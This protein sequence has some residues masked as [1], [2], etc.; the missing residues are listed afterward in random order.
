MMQ[1]FRCGAHPL[2]Q[3]EDVMR[4]VELIVKMPS[5]LSSTAD[6]LV[7]AA[8]AEEEVAS[9]L[10]I[11]AEAMASAAACEA[12]SE[13]K[14]RAIAERARAN[15]TRVAA[16]AARIAA[17]AEAAARA[18]EAAVAIAAEARRQERIDR[19]TKD[20]LEAEQHRAKLHRA[21]R[22]VCV[23]GSAAGTRAQAVAREGG[24]ITR[25]RCK[26]SEEEMAGAGLRRYY[27]D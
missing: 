7:A 13:A 21:R 2:P 16:N 12:A 19:A 8:E 24:C 11:Q 10:E 18:Q 26:C 15:A 23:T 14:A 4:D 3:P 9:T 17:D 27:R 5:L 22:N 1:I 6:S 20:R 25:S